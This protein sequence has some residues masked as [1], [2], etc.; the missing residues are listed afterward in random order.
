MPHSTIGRRPFLKGAL[1]AA[2]LLAVPHHLFA[3][4]MQPGRIPAS[5]PDR[6]PP[7]IPGFPH[8]LHG[9]D[10]N[11]DQWPDEP[12]IID[13]DFRLMEKS[14]CNTFSIIFRMGHARARRGT[15]RVRV[16]RRHHEP[17]GRP[18]LLR[19][20]GDAERRQAALDVRNTPVRRI[21]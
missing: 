19:L 17:A 9:A 2:T 21:N 11:P 1:G 8:I 16:A 4:T 20:R 6:Y 18:W 3:V 7:I 10:W 14:G 12:A 5:L 15:L 13:E